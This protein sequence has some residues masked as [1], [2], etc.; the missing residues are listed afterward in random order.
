MVEQ[1]FVLNGVRLSQLM[2]VGNKGVQLVVP[3]LMVLALVLLV[4]MLV[5]V[6]GR[7]LVFVGRGLRVVVL[8]LMVLLHAVLL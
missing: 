4:H 6:G 1:M 7:L 2:L 5:L 8:L 3:L